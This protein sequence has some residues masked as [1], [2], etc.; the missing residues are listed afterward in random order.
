MNKK[1]YIRLVVLWILVEAF[2]GGIIH[3][4]KIPV[5]GLFVGGAAMI[6]IIL[7][8]Y[9]FPEKGSVLKA[10]FLVAI[11]KGTL[12]P[13]SPVPAYLAVFFQGF[14]GEFLLR[15]KSWFGPS[16]FI[17]GV[18]TMLESALQRILVLV[19]LYGSDFWEAINVWLVKTTGVAELSHF[20]I[21]LASV[22]LI[23]HVLAGLI[24]GR[25]GWKMA[26][27]CKQKIPSNLRINSFEWVE[28]NISSERKTTL[29]AKGKFIYLIFFFIILALIIQAKIQ[30]GAS[31]LPNSGITALLIRF[32]VLIGL[33]MMVVQPMLK[34]LIDRWLEN[35]SGKFATQIA[36]I[37]AVIPE[38]KFLIKESWLLAGSSIFKIRLFLRILLLN[39]FSVEHEPDHPSL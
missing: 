21:I 17:F 22:Y 29:K 39:L 19:V 14:L 37:Q 24:I 3:G 32:F 35:K 36:D 2:L 10:M 13:Q 33:W 5:S 20:S 8:A 25:L 15:N 30:S 16:C 18:V 27:I 26:I 28:L 38:I 12:S 1:L 4:L 23:V 31:I 11:F 6:C 7:I 9:H 34:L